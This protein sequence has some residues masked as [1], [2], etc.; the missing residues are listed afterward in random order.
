[1]SLSLVNT[2]QYIEY[3][4]ILQPT[5]NFTLMC[6]FYA[7]DLSTYKMII[8]REDNTGTNPGYHLEINA[9]QKGGFHGDNGTIMVFTNT[10]IVLNTWYHMVGVRDTVTGNQ[11]IYLNGVLENSAAYGTLSN[12]IATFRIGRPEPWPTQGFIGLMDDARFYN[13]VLDDDEIA[14]IYAC[15]GCDSILYGL[16]GRWLLSEGAKD[17][18]VGIPS[19]IDVNNPQSAQSRSTGSSITLAY[20]APTGNNLVLVVAGTAEGTN[21]ARVIPTSVTFNGN[22]LTLAAQTRTTVSAYNGVG[23]W[24]KQVTSGETG[25]IVV[26][27][28]GSNSRRTVMACV[29]NNATGEVEAASTAFSNTGE[30]TAG[31][32]TLS[33]GS[34]LVTACAN[35]DGFAMTTVGTNHTLITTLVAGGA[36]AGALGNIPVDTAGSITGIGFTASPTPNGEALVV[37]AFSPINTVTELSNNEYTGMAYNRP[38]YGETFLKIRRFS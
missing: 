18:I 26:S 15:R 9:S 23:L 11:R 19:N 35:E 29:L 30:V 22:N 7:T 3:G 14:T 1:M 10:T 21:T 37:A 32:T 16:Q 24:G 20:T 27:W 12:V 34:M 17:Q 36:H 13:R 5:A 31:I 8:G 25:N 6:W 28:A 33:D 4:D 38:T 2:T